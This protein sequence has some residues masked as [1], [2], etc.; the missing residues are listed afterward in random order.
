[1]RNN[2]LHKVLSNF[3]ILVLLFPIGIGFSH[4]LDN[5]EHDICIAK[6][7]KHIHSQKINCSYLHYITHFQYQDQDFN[8]SVLLS[9]FIYSKQVLSLENFYFLFNSS[10]YSVRGPPT[11]NAF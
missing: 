4:S 3:L 7:E 5:D 11:I 8:F 1:M 2:M 10:F 6:T 9:N